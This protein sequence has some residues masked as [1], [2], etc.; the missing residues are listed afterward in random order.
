MKSFHETV[1]EIVGKDYAQ[2]VYYA[3]EVKF[4]NK[5]A[6]EWCVGGAFYPGIEMT[7]LAY[8]K[9]TFHEIY[10]FRYAK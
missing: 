3:Q 9:N 1:K 2:E 6:L 8:D 5:A 7:Y 4:L 10:D